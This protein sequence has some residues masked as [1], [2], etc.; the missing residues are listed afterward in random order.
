MS[1]ANARHTFLKK[2]SLIAMPVRSLSN[3][4]HMMIGLKT[5]MRSYIFKRGAEMKT[6]EELAKGIFG[7]SLAM[8]FVS[9]ITLMIIAYLQR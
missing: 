9:I 8:F 1:M 2:R 5:R 4:T 7:L 6:I 3:T